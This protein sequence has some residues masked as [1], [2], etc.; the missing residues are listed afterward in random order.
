MTPRLRDIGP[1]HAEPWAR[2]RVLAAAL[3]IVLGLTLAVGAVGLP[4]EPGGLTAEVE[5]RVPDS[6][7]T[8]PVTA[9][10]LNFRAYDTWLEVGVL[11][12]AAIG[13][14]AVRQTQD[15]S[16]VARTIPRD[17]M[18]TWIARLLVPLMVL[19]AGF[20]LLLG[21]RA[22]GGAFQAGAVLGAAG[23]ILRLGGF[24]SVTVLG[25]WR[26]RAT[27]ALGFAVFLAVAAGVSIGDRALLEYPAT[28][29]GV[30]ILVIEAAIAIS[31]AVTLTVAFTGADPAANVDARHQARGD[32]R[33]NQ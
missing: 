17:V 14:L 23:V 4:D 27:L 30:L 21:T 12:L 18:V 33:P 5:T 22:P 28:G 26:F 29:A 11:L 10:L 19:T 24:R 25:G 3:V 1:R 31:I 32:V 16:S 13:L 8:H 6:G 7:V 9:V 15:L 20:L 2:T